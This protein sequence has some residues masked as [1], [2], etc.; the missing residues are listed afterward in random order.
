MKSDKIFPS[1]KSKD[2]EEARYGK[3]LS[4][5][6]H[7]KKGGTASGLFYPSDQ[8]IAES[9][10]VYD[11]FEVSCKELSSNE[12]THEVCQWMIGHD[13][14]EPS[15]GSVSEEKLLAS[16]VSVRRRARL[17]EGDWKFYHSDQ[18]IAEEYGYPDL[19]KTRDFEDV[20]KKNT[21]DICDFIKKEGR[22]PSQHSKDDQEKT[23]GRWLVKKRMT[24]KHG[25]RG[26]FYVSCVKIAKSHGCAG[27]FDQTDHETISNNKTH[28]A[29]KWIQEHQGKYPKP[30]SKDPRE[31]TI[32]N[33][34]RWRRQAKNGTTKRSKFYSSDQ[35]IAKKYGYPNLFK[36]SKKKVSKR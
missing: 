33:W 25:G 13:D 11:L 8:K 28:E 29:C 19:F 24:K 17:G 16:W 10:G 4:N 9:Y 36:T 34:L 22:E 35:Q 3:W 26:I 20:D 2:P 27:L 1:Q 15:H 30:T 18:I 31:K 12:K 6:R 23:W 7:V 21:S 5:R 14:N 32:A